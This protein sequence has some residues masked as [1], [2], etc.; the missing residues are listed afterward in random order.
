VDRGP[1]FQS[2]REVA[3]A[4]LDSD[5]HVIGISTQAGAHHVLVEEL[6]VHMQELGATHIKVVCGGVIQFSY[7]EVPRLV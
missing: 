6:F 1:L 5:V 3:R 4:A 7:Q 2:P